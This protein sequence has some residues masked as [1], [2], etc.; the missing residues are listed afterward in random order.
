MEIDFVMPTLL[1]RL[2]H[3]VL[4]FRLLLPMV[5]ML[6]N[7]QLFCV[8]SQI[9]YL[10]SRSPTLP[11]TC[12]SVRFRVRF[13][14]QFVRLQCVIVPHCLA[15]VD[16]SDTPPPVARRR[17][18]RRAGPASGRGDGHSAPRRP[19]EGLSVGD[20]LGGDERGVGREGRL[21]TPSERGRQR[22]G[23]VYMI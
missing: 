2:N 20:G 6:N 19:A 10:S 1:S 4:I 5:A 21:W 18:T 3:S 22:C 12:S 7:L 15:L 8:F 14:A 9:G 16:R 17:G 11:C 13:L 23:T